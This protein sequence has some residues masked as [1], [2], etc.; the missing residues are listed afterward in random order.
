MESTTQHDARAVLA[1]L[2]N[3]RAGPDFVLIKPCRARAGPMGM[4]QTCSTNLRDEH[5]EGH[6]AAASAEQPL[7]GFDH[8]REVAWDA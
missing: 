2:F 6:G 1:R 4:T 5:G 7:A 8:G 3:S